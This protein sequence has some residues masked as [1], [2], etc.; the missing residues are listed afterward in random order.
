MTFTKILVLGSGM[1]ARPCVEYLVRNPKNNVTV[2]CGTLSRAQS[3]ACSLPQ[4]SA[5]SLDVSNSADFE[6]AIQNHNLVISLVPCIYHPTVIKLAIKNQVNVVTA[7][8]VS[9][10]IKELEG[11]AQMAGISVLSEMGVDPG[12]DHLYAVKKIDEF[13]RR[14][15]EFYSYCG[16]LPA[17]E[18]ANNPLGFKFSWSPRG[19]IM[20]QMNS[21]SF[22][23]NGKQVDIAANDLM[24]TA[25]P[26]FVADG[27][28]FV[29]YPNRNSVPFRES[30]NIPEAETVIRGSLRYEGNSAFIKAFADAGWLD[31]EEKGWLKP[32]MTWA[33]ITQRVTGATDSSES[34]LIAR[35]KEKCRFPSETE[36]DR[37]TSGMR[38]FGLFS[39][40]GAVIRGGNLLD[41]L[42]GRLENLL[43]FKPGERDLV[44]LQHKFVVEWEDGKKVSTAP[45][46]TSRQKMAYTFTSTLELL[47]DPKGYSGMSKS[48]GVTCGIAAQLLLDGHPALSTPGIITP[49]KKEIVARYEARS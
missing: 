15:K 41:T 20:S 22:I 28:N 11:A 36:S 34:A 3:I 31:A 26:Y 19:A 48:V 12:V 14:V 32:G 39:S 43:S 49:Y 1:V 2:A 40:D 8:Y 30:Y 7:S 29:A 24:T 35:T 16:G 23:L 37:I 5:T 27:Y 45:C 13:M 21:A 33:N 25:K 9:R 4:T 44:M 10:E 47:G 42:C 18:C 46:R 6:S 17:L 38:Y